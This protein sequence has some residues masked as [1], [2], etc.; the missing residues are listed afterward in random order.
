VRADL[1]ITALGMLS[2]VGLTSGVCLHSVR[3]AISRLS[4]QPYPDFV[5]NWIVG[6]R[7]LVHTPHLRHRRLEDL[8]DLAVSDAWSN[9]HVDGRPPHGPLALLLSAVEPLR[10]GFYFPPDKFDANGWLRRNGV[11][12]AAYVESF[13]QGQASCQAALVR[14]SGLLAENVKH[15]IIGA[16]DSQWQIRTLRWH[17]RKRRLKCSYV[18][19]GLMP[20]EAAAFLIVESEQA[21]LARGADILAIIRSV[22]IE[23]EQASVLSDKP[24]TA[25]GLTA[26]VRTALADASI[27]AK[28]VGAVW[29]DLNGESYRAREWAFTEIRNAFQDHTELIH[30]AD[31]YGDLGAAS[32]TVLLGLAAMA[33]AT[34]WAKGRPILVFGGSEGGVRAA[35]IVGPP[36]S[37]PRDPSI[38]PVT[39]DV[40][41]ILP[42]SH[43]VAELGPDEVDPAESDDPPRAYFEW[44]LRQEHRDELIGLYYQRKALLA[45]GEVEWTRI[46]EP[47][48][49][50][51]NHLDAAAAS[52]PESIWAV[53]SGLLGSDE[54]SCFAGTMMLAVLA[55]SAN[56]NRL[57]DVLRQPEAVNLAGVAA[58]L[59]QLRR[60][61][62]EP[63]IDAWMQHESPGVRAM[64]AT[65]CGRLR[66]GSP[67]K[68][69]SALRSDDSDLVRAAIGAIRRR[70][71]KEASSNLESLLDHAD[72]AVQRESLLALL[73]MRSDRAAEHCRQLCREGYPEGVRA[74]QLLALDGVL[75]DVDYL[76]GQGVA[77]PR[78][79]DLIEAMGIL[80]NIQAVPLL[81]GGLRS[82]DEKIRVAISEA[83]ELMFR[84]GLRET[85]VVQQLDEETSREVE[86]VSTSWNAWSEWWRQHQ[87]RFDASQ[88]WRRG[89]PFEPLACLDE[90]EDQASKYAQRERAFWELTIHVSGEIP[91]EPDWFVAYQLQAI[92]AWRA[93]LSGRGEAVR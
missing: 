55:N 71:F 79:L 74:P 54:G 53:A 59:C 63:R 83:L 7:V 6:G 80:G 87:S 84:S 22:A 57:D 88:R 21:A 52:G 3:S 31:C 44:E 2:P 35:T 75:S 82:E 14:A 12:G 38:F 70:Q 69:L 32:D 19:D 24:N 90:I 78:W 56:W 9:A 45:I 65:L 23:R 61:D 25:A 50:I 18:N 11:P 64:A 33:Q 37:P 51:L 20:S 62:L 47:E 67:G 40:P 76:D 72:A 77:D 28:D 81:I 30:P 93:R 85:A 91:F 43:S 10:P 15:C 66:F 17:E 39:F 16:A 58:G 36:P 8:A 13:P 86:R 48:Q 5:M 34:G 29:C 60:Y 49:R 1:A 92:D 27:A 89:R 73:T 41:R 42:I 4:L 26:A 68:L 46:R